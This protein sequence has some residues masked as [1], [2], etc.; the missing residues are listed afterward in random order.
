MLRLTGTT[1]NL[2]SFMGAI[3]A[4]GIAVANSILLVR[5]AERSRETAGRFSKPPAPAPAAV[6]VPF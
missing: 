5:F 2:Q 3:M 6:C 4:V 1:L